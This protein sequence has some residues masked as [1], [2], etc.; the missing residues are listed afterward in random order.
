MSDMIELEW[1]AGFEFVGKS[2][3]H[4]VQIDGDALK[5]TSP[6]RLLL[7]AVGACTAIDVVDILAKGR[8]DV[9]S[10]RLVVEGDRRSEPPRFFRKLTMRFHIE[11]DVVEAKAQRAVDL[12]L[13]KYCSVFHSLRKDLQVDVELEV[14]GNG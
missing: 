3:D 11:G 12:S 6:P 9:K 10:L 13:E 8:Q 2:G 4:V 14:V 7:E 1:V 5:G